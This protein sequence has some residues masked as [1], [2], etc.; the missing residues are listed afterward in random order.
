MR[1]DKKRKKTSAPP[2]AALA[3]AGATLTALDAIAGRLHGISA[4]LAGEARG[5]DRAVAPFHGETGILPL[6]AA[7][8]HVRRA[9]VRNEPP[10]P[11]SDAAHRP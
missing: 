11:V 4:D 1:E 9:R 10:P 2:Q 7:A 5:N 3:R 6:C 8:V